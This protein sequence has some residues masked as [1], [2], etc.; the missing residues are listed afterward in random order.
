MKLKASRHDA[1]KT[2]FFAE[3]KLQTQRRPYSCGKL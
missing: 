3:I 1:E 2:Q